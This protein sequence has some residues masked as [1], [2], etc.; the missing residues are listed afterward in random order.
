MVSVF[1]LAV[2]GSM[3]VVRSAAGPEPARTSVHQIVA[4][5]DAVVSAR[6]QA[7]RST[8]DVRPMLSKLLLLA[9]LVV[10]TAAALLARTAGRIV[11]VRTWRARTRAW[12]RHAVVRGPPAPSYA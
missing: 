11:E 3:L 7:D 2:A 9:W 1:V 8:L 6:P 12:F 10:L 4:D 5:H